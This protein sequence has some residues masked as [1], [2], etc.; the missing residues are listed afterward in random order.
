MEYDLDSLAERIEAMPYAPW[1]T[2]RPKP[3]L[4]GGMDFS[5]G[6]GL[7]PGD[8]VATALTTP[9]HEGGAEDR[10][11]WSE[12]SRVAGHHIHCARA[13]HYDVGEAA[14]L[15]YGW[16]LSA[17]KPPWADARFEQEFRGVLDHDVKEKGAIKPPPVSPAELP[18]DRRGFREWDVSHTIGV[19]PNPRRFLVKGLMQAGVVHTL[20]ADG[21]AGK[22]FMC[23][24]LG[25]RLAASGGGLTTKWMGADINAEHVQGGTVIMMTAEDDKDEVH[26][27]LNDIDPSGDLRKAAA[28]RFRTIPLVDV[29]GAFPIVAHGPGGEPLASSKWRWTLEQFDQIIEDGG[30]IVAVIID[31][32]ASTLHGE[33]N[34]SNVITE[35]LTEASRLCGRYGASVIVTHH[36]RKQGKDQPIESAEDM[37]M[38]VRGSGAIMGSSRVVWGLWHAS[39][40]QSRLKMLDE[41]PKPG[42]CYQFAVLKANNPQMETGTRV[43][44]RSP[45]GLLEDVT[46]IIGRVEESRR[47][48]RLAWIVHVVGE[49]AKERKPF[50][51]TGQHGFHQRRGE[52][53]HDLQHVSKHDFEKDGGLVDQLIKSKIP[54]KK[55]VSAMMVKPQQTA[56]DVPGGRVAEGQGY[57]DPGSLMNV[58]WDDRWYYW[59]AT[60]EIRSK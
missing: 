55:I 7:S 28:G 39:D 1:V 30:R 5:A 35:Y 25:L 45:T 49:A 50:C 13:G 52:L 18:D 44:M 33:E 40:Y 2:E 27:R 43:L 51:K 6:A 56:L 24:D 57:R 10:N 36:I 8:A 32:L 15:T 26:I 42:V 3:V 19:K 11:R 60:G 9:I 41:E 48:R 4:T 59:P 37:K 22:T 16:M 23:L 53:P 38:A 20:A 54:G 31:T 14:R 46:L 34:R 29:G 47:L 21:G 58:K 17:M 12:F